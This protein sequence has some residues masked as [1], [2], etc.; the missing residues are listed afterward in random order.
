MSETRLIVSETRFLARVGH[1]VRRDN[2]VAVQEHGWVD[3][4]YGLIEL[5]ASGVLEMKVPVT[6][7]L[8]SLV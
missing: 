4:K 8:R 3:Q 1:T 5:H 7:T 6:A 2:G